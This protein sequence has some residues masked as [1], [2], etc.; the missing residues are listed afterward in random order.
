MFFGKKII[1]EDPPA[2]KQHWCCWSRIITRR[3]NFCGTCGKEAPMC[4]KCS[5]YNYEENIFCVKCGN[6]FN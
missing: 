6:K 2:E 3:G 4:V 5:E 1:N